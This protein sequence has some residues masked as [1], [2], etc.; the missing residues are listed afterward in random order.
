MFAIARC[1]AAWAPLALA[2][3]MV[4]PDYVRP[5]AP[6]TPQYKEAGSWK[7]AEPRD[8]IARGNWWSVFGDPQL[9]ALEQQ[10]AVSNQNV[11]VAQAQ[12]LQA[13]A[14]V[15]QAR[16]AVFPMLT[17]GASVVRERQSSTLGPRPAARGTFTTYSLPLDASWEIDLWGGARRAYEA[18]GAGMQATA[19][20]VETV[21]LSSQAALAQDYFLL[22][23]LDAQ[24]QLY[25]DTVQAFER[26]LQL[27]RNRYRSGVAARSEVA[28][29]ETQLRTTQAQAIDLA[30]QRAQLEHAIAILIGKPP[31][32]F[33]L[34]PAPLTGAPPPIPL[35]MPTDLLERRPDVAAAERQMAAANA[36]IGVATAAYFPSLTLSAQGG[37]ESSVL[38]QLLNAPSRFWSIGA[39]LAQTVFDAG[40]SRARTEQAR[41]AYTG[42]IAAYRQTVLNGFQEVEDSLA[43]LRILE[44][45]AAATALA[46]SSA[47][48][49]V[50]LAT[51]QYKA[52][53]ASY[54][55]V[56]IA[57]T[58]ALNNERTEAEILARRMTA[59]VSLV[60]ALGGGWAVTDLPPAPSIPLAGSSGGGSKAASADAR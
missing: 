43:A 59:A 58:A 2:G 24:Q 29:A 28:L 60:K 13:R 56:V 15:A 30:V 22:R 1:L 12:L 52:G 25:N 36:Q 8:A 23:S 5:E 40:L 17:A 9:D 41:A 37:F 39:A 16:A 55:D 32:A 46:V 45:E 49:S 33:S 20:Q 44:E 53:V 18:T 19:A 54:L 50:R 51:N 3:C 34:P 10:V 7:A 42:T 14:L 31:A 6:V 57:Q 47:R 27:T 26:S 11:L 38:S 21:L 35:G 4:G 48:E